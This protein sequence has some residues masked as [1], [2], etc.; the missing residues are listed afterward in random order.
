MRNGNFLLLWASQFVSQVG[1]RLAMVAFPWLVY[2]TTDSAFST[3]VV[4]ALYTLPYVLFGTFAGVVIDRFNKRTVMVLADVL[5]ALLVALVPVTAAQWLPSVYVL[6]FLM[7]SASVFFDPCKLALLP[8]IVPPR[9]LLRANSLLSTG[10]TLTEV[11]GYALAGFLVAYVS[12]TTA[13]RLDAVTFLVS[14]GALAL[15]R[16]RRPVRAAAGQTARSLR[17]EL[18]E[19][20]S[21]IRHHRGLRANTLMVMFAIAGVGAS[22]P[23]TFLFAVQVLEGGTTAFGLLE[24]AIGLGI[25]AGSLTVAAFAVRLHKGLAMTV[26]LAVAGAGLVSVAAT[27]AVWQAM[28]PFV[29]VGIA[30]AAALIAIDTYV[31]E[32]VPEELRGRV[33]GIRFT[34]TQGTYATAVIVTGALATVVDVRALFVAAGLVIAVPAVCGLFVAEIRRA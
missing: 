12:A 30:D 2:N 31:Q 15:M 21:Y 22:Y 6:S 27:D 16:Y 24:A 26:G 8:D 28:I 10:E 33:W 17:R 5:R 14:A 1:D 13:F 23:L 25:F 3:G 19:G 20:L 7:A 4:L 32:I 11:V 29:V 18:R 34:L 9:R